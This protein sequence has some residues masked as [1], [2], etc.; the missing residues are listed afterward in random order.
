MLTSVNFVSTSLGFSS[1]IPI[2]SLST[3]L[4]GRPYNCVTI[5]ITVTKIS[6]VQFKIIYSEKRT[7]K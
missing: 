3:C 5:T 1:D 6:F 2:L 4:A 7:E